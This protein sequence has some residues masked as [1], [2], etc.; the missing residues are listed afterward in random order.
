MMKLIALAVLLMF[1]IPQ[2]LA[3]K[4]KVYVWTNKNGVLVFSDTPKP[5]AEEVKIKT[6]N[7]IKPSSAIETSILDINP[8]VIDE[9]YQVEISHPKNHATVRDNTG[10]LVIQGGIKPIFKSGLK[11][12]LYLNNKKH[13][14]PQGQATFSLHNIDRGEHQIKLVLIDQKGKVIASSETTTF[15]MHRASVN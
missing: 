11:I 5:G 1:F 14:K 8:Q 10:S 7:I 6:Q 4:A 12:Q 13:G 15:Y 3:A 9:K 2:S